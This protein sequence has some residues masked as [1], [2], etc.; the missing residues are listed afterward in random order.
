MTYGPISSGMPRIG[1]LAYKYT[2]FPHRQLPLI[3]AVVPFP[4]RDEMTA[5]FI[6][7]RRYGAPV[8]G[9]MFACSGSTL[10]TRWRW[11]LKRLVRHHTLLA[12]SSP[13]P[14]A[15]SL[16]CFPHPSNPGEP[17]GAW[18]PRGSH[19]MTF[20]SPRY[21]RTFLTITQIKTL[22]IRC[23]N[24]TTFVIHLILRAILPKIYVAS[25]RYTRPFVSVVLRPPFA[26][27]ILAGHDSTGLRGGI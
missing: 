12:L 18:N 5:S 25:T 6:G 9:S 24:P 11:V 7:R 16:A 27:R 14:T 10:K 20:S 3:I 15:R 26:F 8:P 21:F 17:H 23:K 2:A 4:D 19:K 22:T 1:A 13:S